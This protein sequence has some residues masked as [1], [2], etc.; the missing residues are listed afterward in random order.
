MSHDIVPSD[1]GVSG[2]ARGQSRS[3]KQGCSSSPSILISLPFWIVSAPPQP[4]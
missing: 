3:L 4:R 1:Y 2:K